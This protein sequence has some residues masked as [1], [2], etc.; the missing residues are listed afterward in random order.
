METLRWLRVLGDTIFAAGALALV[1]F[2]IG[3]RTGS[4][5]RRLPFDVPAP[6]PIP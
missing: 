6:A 1:V 4:T 2:V 5:A 3:L